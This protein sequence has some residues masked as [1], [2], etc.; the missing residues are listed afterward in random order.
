MRPGT[1]FDQL[2]FNGWQHALE[3][4]LLSFFNLVQGLQADLVNAAAA[5]G[6]CLLAA[7]QMGGDFAVGASR[8]RSFSP[9]QASIAGLLK[10]A[11]HEM[12]AVRTKVVDFGKPDD[13]AAVAEAVLA[14]TGAADGLIEVGYHD[15]IRSM[16]VTDHAPVD[17]HQAN[18]PAIDDKS[19]IL[20]TGGARGITASVVQELAQRYRPTVVLA[21]RSA[22]P[23]EHEARETADLTSAREI[24]AS[25]LQS[26]SRDGKPAALSEVEAA[27]QSLLREREM[28]AEHGA[29]APHRRD[30]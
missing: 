19:V 8:E 25:L 17:S 12:P 13:L 9:A 7:T 6:S 23:P 29:P 24:K 16:I 28:R 3:T 22:M 2:D 4:D 30:C 15:G 21:G 5:G 20:V 10:T 1:P 18:V 27:Y 11:A 26:M 14:E